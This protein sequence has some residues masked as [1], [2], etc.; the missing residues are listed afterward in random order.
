MSSP[1]TT[2]CVARLWRLDSKLTDRLI[3]VW[4]V[5]TKASN[6]TLELYR[7]F[8]SPDEQE[9]A[10]RFRFDHLVRRFVLARGALRLLL[11]RYMNIS[12][13]SIQFRYGAKGK[14]RLEAGGDL[15]FNAS[16]SEDLAV[17]AFT[18]GCEI[19]VD[20]E[21]IHSLPDMQ[22]IAT[23]FFCA[24]EAAE[25]MSL[26][27]HQRQRAFFLCW[28]RKEAYIKAT[29]DGL[30]A[31]LDDFRITLNP[32]DGARFVHISRDAGA[33]VRWMLHNLEIAEDF[34]AALAY[35]DPPRPVHVFP[36][37]DAGELL[38]A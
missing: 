14:P 3:H 10:G 16:H 28:T 30:S 8:L 34:A 33:A 7:Q 23:R 19:G 17:F 4:P 18:V 24:E 9:R 38:T 13:A 27:E 35:R 12:P 11:G 15:R 36:T 22:A 5:P 25:L 2:R 6:D 32:A 37:I 29:G 26:P 20:V 31:P 1:G 21:H